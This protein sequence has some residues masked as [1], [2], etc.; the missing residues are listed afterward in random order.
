MNEPSQHN[1]DQVPDPAP[2]QPPTDPPP[3]QA[4]RGYLTFLLDN[5]R[6][7]DQFLDER[8]RG[9][10]LFGL[11]N[12]GALIALIVLSSWFQRIGAL[13]GR[14]WRWEF[15]L[16]GIKF[17]LSFAIPIALVLFVFKWYS[18]KAGQE[19]SLDFLIEKFGGALTAAGAL[20]LIALPLS[21]LNAT[22]HLWFRG[23]GLVFI[24][25]AVFTICLRYVAPNRLQIAALFTLGFYMSYRL[26]ALLL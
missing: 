19:R 17:G 9:L 7:P 18:G 24:Y 10:K 2:E 11:I 26:I 8:Y 13:G 5:L 6:T 12:M 3:A 22:V 14:G 16:N 15:L 21:L 25:L 20:I 1:P 4:G 23:A